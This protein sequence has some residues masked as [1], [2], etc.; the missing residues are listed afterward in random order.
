VGVQ[1]TL[2]LKNMDSL[3]ERP[4]QEDVADSDLQIKIVDVRFVEHCTIL[5]LSVLIDF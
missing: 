3:L 1:F 4:V 2:K 5:L